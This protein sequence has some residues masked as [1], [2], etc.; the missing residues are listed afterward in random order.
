MFAF[1]RIILD[2]EILTFLKASLS[3]A[4]EAMEEASNFEISTKKGLLSFITSPIYSPKTPHL[5]VNESAVDT[6]CD[7]VDAM[8]KMLQEKIKVAEKDNDLIYHVAAPALESLP[9][10]EKVAISKCIPLA[11]LL[12]NRVQDLAAIVGYDIF[13][14]LVPIVVTLQLSVYTDA[15]DALTRRLKEAH[16][17]TKAELDAMIQ[18]SDINSTLTKLG[19]G[20]KEAK[21]TAGT[22]VGTSFS[23]SSDLLDSVSTIAT[24]EANPSSSLSGMISKMHSEVGE[25]RTIL[26]EVYTLLDQEQHECEVQRV[27]LSMLI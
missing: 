27:L 11:D 18:S 23:P 16:D 22:P 20:L 9:A 2:G 4:N 26:G 24:E 7:T 25:S 10:L 6:L 19:I 17:S 3:Q 21:R 14:K 13:H 1:F 15:K 12:P 5:S 8:V